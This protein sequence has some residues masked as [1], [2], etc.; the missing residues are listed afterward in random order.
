M[1]L[2]LYALSDRFCFGRQACFPL[3]GLSTSSF[4]SPVQAVAVLGPE[5]RE[6][7]L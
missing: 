3:G 6:V 1:S 7:W 2:N 5:Y 4:D